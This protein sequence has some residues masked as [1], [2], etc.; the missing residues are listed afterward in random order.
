MSRVVKLA[1]RS[2]LALS[3]LLA[4]AGC[5]SEAT[6]RVV[7]TV[8]PQALELSVAAQGEIQSAKAVPLKV[9]G[10]QW[11][12]RQLVWMLPEGS[13]VKKGD[14]VARFSADEGELQLSQALIDL[15]RNALARAAKDTELETGQGRVSV[16]LAQVA[17]EL[18]IANRYSGVDLDMFARNE[19]LDA[20]QDAQFL[21]T[22]RD[23]LQWKRDQTAERG[24]AELAV[25]GAQRATYDIN[26]RT[27]QEDLDALELRAPND[28]VLMLEANWTGEKP[29]VGS[30]YRAGFE[31]GSLP[32]TSAMEIELSVPQM[33][34]QA[35][36]AG[37]MVE[38]HPVGRPDQ[39]ITSQLSWV[40]SAAKV[41]SRHSPVK[42]VSMKAPVPAEAVR[43]H[44]LVPGQWV[45]ARIVLLR[46]PEAL[47]VPNVALRTQ[48]GRSYV[49]VLSGGDLARREVTLGTRGPARS[50]VL[51]GLEPGE[52]VLLA[53]PAQ[54]AADADK[55]AGGEPD[56]TKAAAAAAPAA[57]PEDPA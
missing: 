15:Q 30:N 4:L 29:S 41:R 27:R 39:M 32:D 20:V 11:A 6:P 22:K 21:G 42:Y 18:G 57:S 5:G 8:Q 55:P 13:R 10:S 35:I 9:P 44:G 19:V 1:L 33:E 51:A 7:E 24:A 45:Q 47:S 49:Q 37:A 34:A 38:M 17:I 52:Q 40:A 23:T 43:R 56:A 46:E 25:L 26:A 31:F 36:K 50:Q 3:A 16:D 2:L 14:V 53:D 12:A 28:G 54:V 48:D